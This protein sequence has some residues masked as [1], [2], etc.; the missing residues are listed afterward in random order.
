VGFFPVEESPESL[1]GRR[2]YQRRNLIMYSVRKK[3]EVGGGKV[4]VFGEKGS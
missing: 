4:C 3:V 1:G 2:N